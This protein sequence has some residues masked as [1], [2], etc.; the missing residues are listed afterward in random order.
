MSPVSSII[1]L[2][3]SWKH[4]DRCIAGINPQNGRW[5]RPI[6]DLDD[7]RIPRSMRLLDGQ[8]P[9]LLDIINIPLGDTGND[10]GFES[11]NLSVLPGQW[12]KQ[13]EVTA[14]EML[15]YCQSDQYLLH[16]SKKYVTVSELKR[17]PFSLRKTIELVHV[18]EFSI[19]T[20]QRDVG[21][22][23]YKGSITSVHGQRL[24][25]LGITDPLFVQKLDRGD[26]PVVP[27]LVT[28]SLSM[29]H[30]PPNW[31]GD[32]PCWKLIAAVIDLEPKNNSD[33]EL[34]DLPF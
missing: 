28:L 12:K 15:K 1:C 17:K 6:S 29:P 16:N 2:A 32:D 13:G 20:K 3:N 4:G 7:G 22:N 34:L 19:E 11:E 18:T 9:R 14:K 21:I 5:V 10:F 26:Q 8:E 23:Q 31:E 33:D 25:N 30:R 24:K 27:C